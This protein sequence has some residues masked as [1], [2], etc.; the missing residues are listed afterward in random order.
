MTCTTGSRCSGKPWVPAFAGVDLRSALYLAQDA[1]AA[2]A[3]GA[4]H[5]AGLARDRERREER[6]GDR[7]LRLAVEKHV[8][9]A[10]DLARREQF[11][12]ALH[13]DRM[14]RAAA[15]RQ[16]LRHVAPH[17]TIELVGDAARRELHGGRDDVFVARGLVVRAATLDELAHISGSEELA[18]RRLGRLRRE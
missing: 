5:V 12:E 6:E 16:D 13:E 8:V 10:A 9:E 1:R 17:E 18:P 7:L 15:A 11:L 3:G 4:R 2:G 14:A